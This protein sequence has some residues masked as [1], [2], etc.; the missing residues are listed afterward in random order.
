M[1]KKGVIFG[2]MAIV[3]LVCSVM[4]TACSKELDYKVVAF[5]KSPIKVVFGMETET[6]WSHLTIYFEKEEIDNFGKDKYTVVYHPVSIEITF[7]TEVHPLE[8][9]NNDYRVY[10][11]DKLDSSIK[12]AKT[13][14]TIPNV[15]LYG[16]TFSWGD[17]STVAVKSRDEDG[18]SRTHNVIRY[19]EK[20]QDVL[21]KSNY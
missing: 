21:K 6:E 5:D 7:N 3:I 2:L 20:A 12:F 1:K 19:E 18:F 4:L 17:V 10:V 15:T 16:F 8:D 14:H 11:N 13:N 9:L